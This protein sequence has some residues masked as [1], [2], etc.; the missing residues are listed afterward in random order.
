MD[1]RFS[2]TGAGWATASLRAD[3]GSLELPASHLTEALG[4]LVRALATLVAGRTEARCSWE[5]EPGGL[6]D[7]HGRRV[8]ETREP[9]AEIVRAIT[10]GAAR[11][12]AEHGEAGYL[13]KWVLHALPTAE[14]NALQTWVAAN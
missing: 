8:F 1:F 13:D 2:L 10:D 6:A 4:D 12:L 9:L 14:L 5:Q 3:A 11:V 7:D